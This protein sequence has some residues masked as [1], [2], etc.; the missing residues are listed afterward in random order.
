MSDEII[1]A[2]VEAIADA[3]GCSPHALEF[4]LYEHADTSALVSLWSSDG[5][6]W[7]LSFDV[8]DHVATVRGTGEILVDD[9]VI[10]NLNGR[11]AESRC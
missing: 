10:R 7:E 5:D 11:T 2:V 9:T 1:P 6:D 3:E 8:P 4:A